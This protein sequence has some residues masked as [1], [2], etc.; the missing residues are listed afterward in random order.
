MHGNKLI[1]GI[2]ALFVIVVL[3]LALF[4]FAGDGMTDSRT[5]S[6]AG[7]NATD[8]PAIVAGRDFLVVLN[9]FERIKLST[10]TL[11]DR[12]FLSLKDQSVTLPEEPLG[13]SNP[14]DVLGAKT[15][16]SSGSGN[17]RP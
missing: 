7:P 2:T 1:I 10:S 17:R 4:Y 14:F 11:E 6:V 9:K 16:T 13:R 3:G 5:L 8:T 15:G 12:V